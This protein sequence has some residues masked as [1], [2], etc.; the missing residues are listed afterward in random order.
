[1]IVIILQLHP[2]ITPIEQRLRNT[3]N[4]QIIKVQQTDGFIDTRT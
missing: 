4:N 3:T 1:M 2:I